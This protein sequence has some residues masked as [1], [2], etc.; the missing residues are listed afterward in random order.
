MRAHYFPRIGETKF[1]FIE[2]QTEITA[3]Q[4]ARATISYRSRTRSSDL[5]AHAWD[6]S[7]IVYTD[8]QH[9][10]VHCA[11]PSIATNCHEIAA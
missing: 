5:M 8:T 2:S 1:D 7:P 10:I 3:L 9:A 11:P 4:A 6:L